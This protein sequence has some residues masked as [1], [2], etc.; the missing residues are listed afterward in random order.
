[1]RAGERDLVGVVIAVFE[2]GVRAELRA[3]PVLVEELEREEMRP[4]A[5][6]GSCSH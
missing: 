6:D 5:Y 1:M 2:E 3:E 4:A